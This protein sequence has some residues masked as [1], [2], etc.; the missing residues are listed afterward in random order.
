MCKNCYMK[1][2]VSCKLLATQE[3]D[4]GKGLGQTDQFLFIE[5]ALVVLHKALSQSPMM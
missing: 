4:V 3:L 5:S 1:S 2:I